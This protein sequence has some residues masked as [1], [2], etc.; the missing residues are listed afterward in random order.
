MAK[1][2][3]IIEQPAQEGFSISDIMGMM[4]EQ[5]DAREK[6][7]SEM[8]AKLFDKTSLLMISRLDQNLGLHI[9]KHMILLE[10]FQNY[11]NKVQVNYILKPTPNGVICEPE[12][13]CPD[14]DE[15]MKN[16][17]RTVVESILQVTISFEGQGRKEI[18]ETMM[19]AEAKMVQAEL[20]KNRGM[21]GK[22][23]N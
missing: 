13:I 2:E 5:K 1:K 12:Y 11:W 22:I 7:F 15:H 23:L 3:T 9:I 10:M 8:A 21:M 16:A 20:L 19:S 17:Y 14:L 18:L 6:A 4:N